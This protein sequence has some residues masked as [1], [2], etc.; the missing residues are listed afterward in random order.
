MSVNSYVIEAEALFDGT[1]A[2]PRAASVLVRDGLIE[3]LRAPGGFAGLARLHVS[4]LAPGFVDLQIN[5]AAD[6]QFNDA[7]EPETLRRIACGAAE[8]GTAWCLPT[9]IT[10]PG[11]AYARALDAAR[12][13][14]DSATPGVIGLHLEG[15]FLS[16]RRPGIHP[17]KAIRPLDEA[18]FALLE[19][20]G[21]GARLI[22]VAPETI[23]PKAVARLVAA[24]WTVFAGHSEASHAEALAA[25]GAGLSG[26]THLFNAMSQITPRE[27][28]LVG[29]VLS[30]ALPY[31]GVI[32]D[33]HHVH[34]ENLRL[35]AQALGAGRLCLVTDAMLTL[36]GTRRSFAIGERE[37]T[38]KNGRLVDADGTLGGA[39]L[40]MDQA[41][42][43]MIDMA[44]VLPQ[45]AIRMAS[46]TPADV[47]GLGDSIGHI[48]PG[49][50]AG[51]VVMD[52]ALHVQA[53][54]S[55]GAVL[56]DPHGLLSGLA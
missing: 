51:L 24:G 22:T 41:V 1:G 34:P 9:F 25:S 32:A 8:G 12:A 37:V 27:P 54:I 53:T 15:P 44:G 45:D 26:A 50:R 48:A 33:G 52:E 21:P 11:R 38:L 23:G 47:I 36:A 30:G 49:Y 46:A 31:A 16:P 18:D 7:P 13:A 19:A 42:R 3:A 2:A 28:G 56:Y 39:H 43:N 10:A 40:A 55:D 20:P 4:V 14:L 29:A 17:P 35:A 5:G 6:A